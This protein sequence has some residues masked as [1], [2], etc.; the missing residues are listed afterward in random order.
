MDRKQQ[1][2]GIEALSIMNSPTKQCFREQTVPDILSM[3]L[4]SKS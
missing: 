2:W 1:F 4:S 3:T